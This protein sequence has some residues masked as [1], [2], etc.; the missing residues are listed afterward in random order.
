MKKKRNQ[1]MNEAQKTD[2]REAENS[3]SP[4]TLDDDTSFDF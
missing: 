1:M 4:G 2:L 3:Y